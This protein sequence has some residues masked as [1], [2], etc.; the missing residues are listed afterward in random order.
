MEI[1]K[2]IPEE[3]IQYTALCE[4]VFLEGKRWDVREAIRNPKEEKTDGNHP[5]VWGAFEKGTLLSAMQINP[6]TLNMNGH[7]VQMGGIGGVATRPEARGKGLIRRL[8]RPA[9]E[10]MR[11]M[12]Q[13]YSF[14]YPFS[15]EYYRQFGYEMCYPC[16]QATIPIS[17]FKH[18]PYPDNLK[19]HEPEEDHAP[20]KQIYEDFSRGR[21]LSAV[22]TEKD[23]KGLLNRDPYLRLQF[24]FL[25]HDEAGNPSSYVLYE[26]GVKS[27]NNQSVIKIRELCWTTPQSLH[28]IFGFFG[29]MGSEYGA[30]RW[31]VPDGLNIMAIL[32]DPY[33]IDWKINGVGMNRIVDVPAVLSMHPAPTGSGCVTLG[34]TDAFCPENTGLYRMEWEAGKL[35]ATRHAE[36]FAQADMETAVTTLAQLVTGYAT[37][38]EVIYRQD[39]AIRSGFDALEMLFP[40]KDLYLLERF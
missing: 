21:N 22:R 8:S 33:G 38:G 17:Q 25:N 5:P 7:K 30:V 40:K 20:F 13:V 6:Y 12:G 34:V 27:H 28:E 31:H 23:W 1:R 39:T 16:H 36:A 14:L 37:P 9:F 15:Y 32:P 11:A 10:E 35:T 24:T 2:L 3:R 18:F 29:K 26:T 4:S 19:A